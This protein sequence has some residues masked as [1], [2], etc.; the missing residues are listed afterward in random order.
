MNRQHDIEPYR[1]GEDDWLCTVEFLPSNDPEGRVFA[2]DII[3]Y[4]FGYAQLTNARALALVGDPEAGAYELLF[5]FSKPGDKGQFLDLVRSNGDMEG[6]GAN[7]A[8]ASPAAR[9]IGCFWHKA[10]LSRLDWLMNDRVTG[11]PTRSS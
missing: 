10:N 2:A 1:Q 6:F 8:S 11:I 9:Q 3:G 4:L 7:Q 5:S